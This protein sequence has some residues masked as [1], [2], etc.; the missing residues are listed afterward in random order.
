MA[1]D[2]ASI[3]YFITAKDSNGAEYTFEQKQTFSKSKRAQEP[4]TIFLSRDS[5][6]FPASDTGLIDINNLI[7]SRILRF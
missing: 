4:V 1:N 7:E 2:S 6:T 5:I 3:T